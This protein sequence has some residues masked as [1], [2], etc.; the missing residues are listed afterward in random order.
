MKNQS[1]GDVVQIQVS[2]NP[3]TRQAFGQKSIYVCQGGAS[4][5]FQNRF[6]YTAGRYLTIDGLKSK[7]ELADIEGHAIGT[8][9]NRTGHFSCSRELFNEIYETDLWT[10]RANTVEGYTEDCP[11][12]ERLGYGEEQFATAWGCGIPNY[13]VGAFY[14]NVLRVLARRATTE[15]LV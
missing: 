14:T 8:D 13:A 1:P 9:L 12:R 10:F 6:N 2:D 7:P 15:R 11:H 5:T 4:E 3:G